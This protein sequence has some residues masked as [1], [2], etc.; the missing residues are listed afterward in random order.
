MAQR[1]LCSIPFVTHL[2][3]IINMGLT[4]QGP[5]GHLHRRY[6]TRSEP[7]LFQVRVPSLT[8]SQSPLL[9]CIGGATARSVPEE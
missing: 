5:F 8:R 9:Q 3:A 4:F 7:P 2:K 6:L 1:R